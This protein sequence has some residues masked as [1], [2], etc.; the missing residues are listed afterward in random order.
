G[1]PLRGHPAQGLGRQPDLG[2]SAS[3]GGAD[4]GVADVLATGAAGRG[5]PQSTAS[6]PAGG[7]GFAPV[8]RHANSPRTNQS[9]AIAYPPILRADQ[10]N[11]NTLSTGPYLLIRCRHTNIFFCHLRA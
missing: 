9:F 8:T 2:R 3:S 4:V 1:H 10:I 5:L 11:P 6:R 7:P